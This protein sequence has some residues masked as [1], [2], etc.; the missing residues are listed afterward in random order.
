MSLLQSPLQSLRQS[1]P[2]P[3]SLR[4]SL[5]H[6]D[7]LLQSLLQPFLQSLPHSL[8][9]SPPLPYLHPRHNHHPVEAA[10]IDHKA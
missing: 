9:L 3:D 2:H 10:H 8:L 5:P 7:S 4:Q 6:P 1:L